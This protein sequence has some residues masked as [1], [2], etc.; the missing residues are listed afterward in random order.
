MVGQVL[1]HAPADPDGLWIHRSAAKALNARD[2]EDMRDGFRT[3][4]LNSRGIHGFSAG[5]EERAL[6][7]KYREQAEQVEAAGFQ[8]L[9]SSLRELAKHYER[10][11]ERDSSRDPFED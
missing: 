3:A 7:V 5:R 6:A 9:A 4:L 1:I 8:R 2:A 10:E 11:A